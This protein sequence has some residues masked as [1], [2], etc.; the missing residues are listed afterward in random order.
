MNTLFPTR[1]DRV[2][3]LVRSLI[4]LVTVT[5]ISLLP[6]IIG[7]MGL[8]EW[9]LWPFIVFTLAL[10]ALKFP[11]LDIPRIRSIGWSPWF[12]LLF[13]VPVVGFILQGL[14]FVIRPK[15]ANA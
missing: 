9:T 6:P 1:L 8:A 10:V 3:Y 4:Y 5:V 2:Q 11:C 12:L 7:Y 13:I 15:G 14:L